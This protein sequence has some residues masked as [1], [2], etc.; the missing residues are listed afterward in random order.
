MEIVR[1][2]VM[3]SVRNANSKIRILIVIIKGANTNIREKLK[4]LKKLIN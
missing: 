3:L 2:R 1:N 4:R